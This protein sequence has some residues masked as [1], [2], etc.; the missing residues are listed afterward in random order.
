[1]MSQVVSVIDNDTW[2]DSLGY[3]TL[4]QHSLLSY[5]LSDY[6]SISV[7][8]S[9]NK[10]QLIDRPQTTGSSSTGAS[11]ESMYMDALL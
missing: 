9:S 10:T 2:I 4:L 7:G 8:I 11:P 3:A 1:M 5:L 6:L